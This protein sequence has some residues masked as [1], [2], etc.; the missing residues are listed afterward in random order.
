MSKAFK[1]LKTI[2]KNILAFL[3]GGILGILSALL[4]AVPLLE[5]AVKKDVGLGVIV[6]APVLIVFYGILFGTAG[7][8][9]AII[10]YNL[11]KYIKRKRAK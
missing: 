7:G 1:I 8:I 3:A 5:H 6:V 11:I 9:L 10:L 4:Y 2:F